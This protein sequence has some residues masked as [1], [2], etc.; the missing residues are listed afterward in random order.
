[1]LDKHTPNKSAGTDNNRR[2]IKT[3]TNHNQKTVFFDK[4]L[5]GAKGK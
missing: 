2:E 5:L 1:L 3:E 4:A